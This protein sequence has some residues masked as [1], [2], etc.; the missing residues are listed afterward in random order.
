L[1]IQHS[2]F[3]TLTY[4]A[5][6]TLIA[7]LLAQG[8]T[9]GPESMQGPDMID[10][11]RLNEQR[12][13]RIDKTFQLDA[14][15]KV[16]LESIQKPML[17]LTLTE[18]WCGDAAQ[19]VPVLPAL[20]ALNPNIEARFLLRD[21]HPD[22][23]ELFLTDSTRSIPKVIFIEPQSGTVLGSWGP[24]PVALQDLADQYKAEMQA[25]RENKLSIKAKF[26]EGKTA[27]HTWYAHD[28]TVSTQRELLAA[29]VEA[30]AV[31]AS[32]PA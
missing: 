3:T 11:A 6:R 21:E 9:T 26:E 17:W 24:R 1:T 10:Y 31:Q 22:L 7:D 15:A 18:G 4:E 14:E 2:T 19:I 5:Y 16:L 25:M 27:I 20:A 29:A 28:K 8:K 30:A 13:K 12:M 32:T 23:M